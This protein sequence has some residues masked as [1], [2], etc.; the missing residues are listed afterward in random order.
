MYLCLSVLMSVRLSVCLCRVDSELTVQ[1]TDTALSRD[2]FPHD[3]ECLG[4]NENRPVKWLAIEA[5]VDR[6]YSSATD[7]VHIYD[8]LYV[9]YFCFKSCLYAIF[10]CHLFPLYCIVCHLHQ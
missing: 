2:L 10:V 9:F 7:A 5:L 4:D 3:Y 6:R 8:S 1:L